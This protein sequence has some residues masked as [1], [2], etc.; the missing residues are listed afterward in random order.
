MC[1]NI[2]VIAYFCCQWS[3]ITLPFLAPCMPFLHFA[4]IWH[5]CHN[6]HFAS[7]RSYFSPL[8]LLSRC[9]RSYHYHQKIFLIS[10]VTC[11]FRRVGLCFP[12]T[13]PKIR[14][15][16]FAFLFVQ[17]FPYSRGP[18]PP[19]PPP[20]RGAGV[21]A[22]VGGSSSRARTR[23]EGAWWALPRF[24]VNL[25]RIFS[26]PFSQSCLTICRKESCMLFLLDFFFL[27]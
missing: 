3:Y 9:H 21:G 19:P 7:N 11:P 6:C 4:I 16:P 26:F 1:C 2:F 17:P 15:F 5:L 23:N 22:F 27:E 10:V 14:I 20:S 13:F 12:S 24:L 18:R 8:I 25:I